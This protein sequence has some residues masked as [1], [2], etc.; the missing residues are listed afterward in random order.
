MIRRWVG[1]SLPVLFLIGLIWIGWLVFKPEGLATDGPTG[2]L[3]LY[4]GEWNRDDG[5]SGGTIVF[6]GPCFYVETTSETGSTVRTLTALANRG[7]R[8][9]EED[10][11][12]HVP[13]GAFA[14]GDEIELGGGEAFDDLSLH[15]WAVPPDPACDTSRVW[16]AG[17]PDD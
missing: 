17:R 10:Q 1:R 15:D 5:M 7:T 2:P 11:T 16:I 12:L 14:Q 6:D 4:N 8:W 3:A 13:W 9:D